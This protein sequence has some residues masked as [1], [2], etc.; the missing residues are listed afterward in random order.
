MMFYSHVGGFTPVTF[1]KVPN[2]TALLVKV[3]QKASHYLHYEEQRHLL[4][5]HKRFSFASAPSCAANERIQDKTIFGI[6]TQT[7]H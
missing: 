5:V 2:L 3:L 6:A 4:A 7:F 1:F